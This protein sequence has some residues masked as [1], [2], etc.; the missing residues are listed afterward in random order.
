M[1]SIVVAQQNII[2]FPKA[3]AVYSSLSDK[4][5]RV[6]DCLALNHQRQTHNLLLKILLRLRKFCRSLVYLAAHQPQFVAA[7]QSFRDF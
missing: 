4:S 6:A 7:A 3:A 2:S 1:S 5:A